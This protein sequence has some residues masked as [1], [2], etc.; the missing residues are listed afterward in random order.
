MGI[1][2]TVKCCCHVHVHV[3]VQN[4]DDEETRQAL[5]LYFSTKL[6]TEVQ[7]MVVTW[8]QEIC[9]ICMSEAQGLEA[10]GHTYQANHKYPYYN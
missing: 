10:Q 1:I 6:F 7:I 4:L 9:L 8:M 2:Y 5:V 3:H